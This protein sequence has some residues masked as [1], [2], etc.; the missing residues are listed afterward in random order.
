MEA[1]RKGKKNLHTGAFVNQYSN[2]GSIALKSRIPM[3]WQ[4]DRSGEGSGEG[5]AEGLE[6]GSGEGSAE[7]SREGSG[8]GYRSPFR[9]W[10]AS[11]ADTGSDFVR[12]S[13]SAWGGGGGLRFGFQFG[14]GPGSVLVLVLGYCQKLARSASTSFR[15]V[16]GAKKKSTTSGRVFDHAQVEGC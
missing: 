11:M 9:A 10:I 14:Q 3:A 15:V 6:E 16:S 4:T 13:A 12:R 5:S 1:L 8:V 2:S 7:R